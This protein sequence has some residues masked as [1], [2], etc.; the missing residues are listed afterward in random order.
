MTIAELTA[1]LPIEISHGSA[2]VVISDLVED[3]RA[4]TPGCLFV[5]RPGERFD[6]RRYIADAIAAGAVAVL[7]DFQ[8]EV[9]TTVAALRTT[10]VPGVTARVAERHFVSPSR[11]LTL[12]GITGT[13]G[14]TTTA[15]LTHQLLTSAGI[16]CGLIGT[17]AVD[18]GL[19]SG[20]ANLTT[21]DA[22]SL[23]RTLRRM[24]DNGCTACVME[25]SSHALQQGRVAALD[26][27]IACFTNLSGDHLDYHADMDAYAA[28]KA[29]LFEMLAPGGHAV[30]NADD[31]QWSRMVERC[32]A[33]VHRCSLRDSSAE[34]FAGVQQ[35]TI[36]GSDVTLQVGVWSRA[37][38]IPLIGRHNVINA[39]QALAAA[40]L[41][42]A[43]PEVARSSIETCAAPPGRFECVDTDDVGFTILVDY[44][45]TDDAL[46]NALSALRPL[47]PE[48]ARLYV[49]FGCGGDR[50]RTKRPRMAAAACRWADIVHITS[51][52]PR[53]EDPKSIIDEIIA[54]VPRDFAGQLFADVDRRTAIHKAVAG[55]RPNDVILVAGKGHEDY[56]IIGTQKMPFDDRVVAK[57]AVAALWEVPV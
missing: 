9:P 26:F 16:R 4:A 13:N 19:A 51:D 49:V 15:H 2:A 21:P 33:D 29:R 8:A 48:A 1:N 54:G 11:A 52:N 27:D 25:V 30:A 47:V 41:A 31:P 34:W 45:H 39:L 24:V 18:D 50:D 12:I 44:A 38:H 28:A 55:A 57:Q 46:D 35:P 56:Q 43:D 20:P 10:D 22:I 42:G 37:V 32:T 53:T 40:T 14:K 5:A 36:A 6:G 7:T 23:S 17:V 3:S